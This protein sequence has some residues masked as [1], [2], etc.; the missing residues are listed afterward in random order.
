M[1]ALQ[2]IK[3]PHVSVKKGQCCGIHQL[4]VGRIKGRSEN[5]ARHQDVP[6]APNPHDS[7]QIVGEPTINNIITTGVAGD[8]ATVA[9]LVNAAPRILKAPPGLLLMTDIGVPSYAWQTNS[10][11]RSNYVHHHCARSR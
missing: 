10:K 7:V 9:S 8:G 2:D 4:A 1:V 3:T 11:A 5:H 6:Q